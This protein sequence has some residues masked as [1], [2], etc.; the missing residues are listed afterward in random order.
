MKLWRIQWTRR[1]QRGYRSLTGDRKRMVIELLEDLQTDPRPPQA[2]PLKTGREL[3][4][5]YK[6]KIDGWRVVYRPKDD[7]RV[8]I[9]LV[10]E[11]RSKDTYL[12]I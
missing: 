2:E 9:I 4:G 1:A 11:P 8:V 6:V 7:D 10:I 12:G 3:T 5:H